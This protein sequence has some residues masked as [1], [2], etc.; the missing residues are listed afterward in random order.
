MSFPGKCLLHKHEDLRLILIIHI[1]NLEIVVHDCGPKTNETE[2]DRS[3]SLDS[4]PTLKNL[5]FSGSS[6]RSHIK[7]N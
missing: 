6:E 1:K 3:L 2:T 5:L 4:E 7:N